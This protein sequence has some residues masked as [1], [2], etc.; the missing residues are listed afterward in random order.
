V[1]HPSIQFGLTGQ[2]TSLSLDA[3]GNPVIAYYVNS[4]PNDEMRLAHCGNATCTSGNSI[5][6]VE[7]GNFSNPTLALDAAGDPVMMYITGT[8]PL[9]VVHC[10]DPDCAQ[11]PV[12][13]LLQS[14]GANMEG[15]TTTLALDAAG[16]PVYS[17][18]HV[19]S[20]SAQQRILH[21]G[22]ANCTSG[23]VFSQI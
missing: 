7:M 11:P 20:R 18:P 16:N 12:I 14:T 17:Y 8:T 9:H 6:T 13:T 15:G 19:L 21:C 2:G 4:A 22:D 5:V 1:D 3:A 23:N 10:G